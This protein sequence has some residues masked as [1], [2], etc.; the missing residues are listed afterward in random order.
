MS[1][2]SR[3]L[4]DLHLHVRSLA[5]ALLAR[6]A[7]AGIPLTVTF[8][9]R[10]PA[11]QAA[12]YA[13]GRTTPGRVVTNARAGESFHN[14]G[15]AFDVVPTALL[16]LPNWGDTPAHQAQTDARSSSPRIVQAYRPP[17]VSAIQLALRLSYLAL[18]MRMLFGSMFEPIARAV[19]IGIALA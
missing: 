17:R 14:Y 13:Q 12:L 16:A 6:S 4:A 11:T 3:G 2:D 7:A 8:T 1:G 9:Y 5:E 10:S 19:A 15:L 18:K